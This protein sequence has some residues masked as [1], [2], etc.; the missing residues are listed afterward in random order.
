M[1]NV[2]L[3][4]KPNSLIEFYIGRFAYITYRVHII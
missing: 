3:L 4:M 1:Q 2:A